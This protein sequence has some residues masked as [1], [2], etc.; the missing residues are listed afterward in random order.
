[1]ALVVL[2]LGASV[3]IAAATRAEYV[4]QA[5]PY[6][7]A[8]NKDIKAL[9][10][11]FHRLFRRGKDKAAGRVLSKTGTR[12]SRSVDEVRAIAPPP[13]DEA[14]VGE[15][16]RLVDQIAANNHVMGRAHARHQFRKQDGLYAQNN[17][18]ANRAHALVADWGFHACVG[19]TAPA[20]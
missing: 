19:E 7:A 20:V 9:N 2:L 16:L 5:D 8:A 17:R 3:A 11:R 14:L 4:S 1:M 18:I 10:Q 15:W 13:G 6:C 12:L